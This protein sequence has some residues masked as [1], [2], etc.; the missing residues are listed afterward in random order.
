[1]PVPH[2]TAKT[3][4]IVPP[5][6]PPRN[7]PRPSP[8]KAHQKSSD[9]LDGQDLEGVRGLAGIYVDI[10]SRIE[11]YIDIE[12]HIDVHARIGTP[13]EHEERTQGEEH[14][15]GNR[16][17][18]EPDGDGTEEQL[19]HT[20]SISGGGGY[21]RIR[22]GRDPPS[23]HHISRPPREPQPTLGCR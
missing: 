12:V 1:M 16:W 2:A 14:G 8:A 11:I 18:G 21:W 7:A 10:G 19:L 15:A 3:T 13:D 9:R 17:H 4:L 20:A 6:P 23:E 5:Q 22:G